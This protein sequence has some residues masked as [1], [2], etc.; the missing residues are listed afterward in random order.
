MCGSANDFLVDH[1][2]SFRQKAAT[3]ERYEIEGASIER[4]LF[5]MEWLQENK[6]NITPAID[7][8]V[9]VIGLFPAATDREQFLA[10]LALLRK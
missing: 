8:Y 10:R 1:A 5:A 6:C 9:S 7:A 4:Y 2:G 3:T